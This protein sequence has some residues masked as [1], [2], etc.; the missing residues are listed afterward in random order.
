MRARGAK[1]FESLPRPAKG[2]VIDELRL[3]ID[4]ETVEALLAIRWQIESALDALRAIADSGKLET[5]LAVF[6]NGTDTAKYW[7]VHV[8]ANR[9]FVDARAV[10]ALLEGLLSQ[11]RS[12]RE[13]CV[14]AIGD[15]GP[16]AGSVVEERLIQ[17]IG[18]PSYRCSALEVLGRTG[19][20]RSASA[21]IPL[22]CDEH[23]IIRTKAAQS[24]IQLYPNWSIEI[25]RNLLAQEV[26]PDWDLR[27]HAAGR[28]IADGDGDP[29]ILPVL[30][31]ALGKAEYRRAAV[32]HL[33]ALRD[34]RAI[35]P[36]LSALAESSKYSE[37]AETALIVTALDQ[38]DASWH[39]CDACHYA[40]L[41]EALAKATSSFDSDG[42]RHFGAI[43]AMID[44]SWRTG[45]LGE[46]A[47]HHFTR[48]LQDEVGVV[49]RDAAYALGVIGNKKAIGALI[50]ALS[51]GMVQPLAPASQWAAREARGAVVEALCSIGDPSALSALLAKLED[52]HEDNWVRQKA[53]SAIGALGNG[54]VIQSLL[55]VF[56]LEFDV[57]V[58]Q[59][60]GDALYKLDEHWQALPEAL[61]LG[62]N[63]RRTL[64]LAERATELSNL[65]RE[66]RAHRLNNWEYSRVQKA[67][68]S[69]EELADARAVDV[70]LDAVGTQITEQDGPAGLGAYVN[71]TSHRPFERVALKAL[72]GLA[73][74]QSTDVRVAACEALG[75]SEDVRAFDLLITL[76]KDE[77][78][79]V[80]LAACRA[81]GTLG[82]PRGIEPLVRCK[83]ELTFPDSIAAADAIKVLRNRSSTPQA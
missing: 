57:S 45:E 50:D 53:A 41:I 27:F 79:I 59:A 62:E 25:A 4:V 74:A 54:D 83:D 15:M 73:D 17:L 42:I 36:L 37:Q 9:K 67:C 64:V 20:V 61:A 21:I 24:L 80:R 8:L 10:T 14:R 68:E 30:L 1:V 12:V 13:P 3:H 28:L 56:L 19:G 70:L 31:E 81:L 16:R 23:N 72:R 71:S 18:S 6:E 5:I 22:L 46:R 47:V 51:V 44:P 66:A 7:A 58:R 34:P 33:V 65:L 78:L 35:R 2:R 29:R 39:H 26:N 48:A 52:I 43:L 75:R 60:I 49:R 11:D 40:V 82:D 38:V 63:L 76:L 69:L 55:R 77:H 32:Q